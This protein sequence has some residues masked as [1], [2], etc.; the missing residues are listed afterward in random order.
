MS[1]HQWKHQNN[2]VDIDYITAGLKEQYPGFTMILRGSKTH[3][4]LT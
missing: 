1:S 2:D 3:L 4:D